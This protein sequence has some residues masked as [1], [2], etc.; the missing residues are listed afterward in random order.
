MRQ[1]TYLDKIIHDKRVEVEKLIK[2]D[3]KKGSNS[4]TAFLT[5]QRKSSGKFSTALKGKDLSVI[6][7]IKR[8]SPSKGQ[9]GD[10]IDPSLLALSYAKG[11][12]SAISV[13][14]DFKHFGGSLEDLKSAGQS[15]IKV[16]AE[17][18]L[19]RKDFLIHKLQLCE[20]AL[21]GA[22]AVLL[23]AD[24]LGPN[25]RKMIQTAEFL[26]LES[27]VEVHD[28]RDLDIAL[29]AGANIIGVNNRDLKSFNIDLQTSEVLRPK[30][31]ASII[32]VSESG[33]STPEDARRMKD[34]GYH[35]ILVGEALVKSSDPANL[36]TAL[37]G[38][39]N[40]N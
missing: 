33:I 25:L 36:L 22:F 15:L 12:A 37:K 7:E 9:I 4:L 38:G 30:I 24:V 20:A 39:I 5:N 19:L 31:P 34:L 6:A 8:A 13:L 26:G 3:A 40:E 23:I 28:E 2:E 1:S 11:G 32:T 17:V 10:I 27:L 35:A 14:T 18:P 16:G 29:E 21:A